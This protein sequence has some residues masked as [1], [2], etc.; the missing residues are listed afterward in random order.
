MTV[1]FRPPGVEC[2]LDCKYCYQ[3]ATRASGNS[4]RRYNKEAVWDA[5]S[6]ASSYW[7]LFGGEALLIKPAEVEELLALAHKQFGHSGIQTNGT[8]I[9]EQHIEMFAKYKTY[10]GFSIDGPEDLNDV[11]WAGT[12][13]A[14]RSH[15]ARSCRALSRLLAEAKAGRSP[16]PSLIVTL[17]AGNM[18]TAEK[19]ERLLRWFHELDEEGLTSVNLH[20]ME[21]DYEANEWSCDTPTMLAFLKELWLA[22]NSTLH[23][24][25][26]GMFR[27]IISLLRGDDK[28]VKCV[29]HACDPWNTGAVEGLEGDG[30]PS[31]CTRINKDGM[32]WMPASGAGTPTRHSIGGYA[33]QRHHERQLALYVTPQEY[34]GCKDCRFW[35]MC[36]GQCPGTGEASE[37]QGNQGDWRFRSSYCSIWKGLFEEGER[38]LIAVGEQPLSRSERLPSLERA[39]YGM[40]VNGSTSSL[41]Q[42][43]NPRSQ[44]SS[45]GNVQHGDTP[46][47]NSHGDH[48]D[49][50]PQEHGNQHGDHDD[51]ALA[52]FN[53][54]ADVPHANQHGDHLDG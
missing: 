45:G 24:L 4:P 13:E 44:N 11:R 41:Q 30:T 53:S 9:T 34:G 14:T 37:A 43:L 25:K 50:N 26:F 28:N 36:K 40:W 5:L 33:A 17:H 22:E 23:T 2:N 3:K 49:L 10:V 38:R 15:T 47:G 6:N 12:E 18:G 7:S 29:W 39:L 32:T 8:L 48:D 54:H 20:M 42:L 16:G 1:E 52:R 31:G 51:E 35:L 27:E 21:L 46:H 19:R